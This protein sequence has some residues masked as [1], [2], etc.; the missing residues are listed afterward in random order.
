MKAGGQFVRGLEI[1]ADHD[2]G[3]S[4]N[5]FF[6]IVDFS[7]EL[8]WNWNTKGAF[9]PLI[10][11]PRGIHATKCHP[12]VEEDYDPMVLRDCSVMTRF[13]LVMMCIL[14]S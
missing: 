6:L 14:P 11:T 13:E 9:T 3:S 4:N 5:V 7:L 2:V 1:E 12:V 10:D 8:R